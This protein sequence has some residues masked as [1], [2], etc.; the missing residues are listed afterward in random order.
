MRELIEFC[1]FTA[2]VFGLLTVLI[3]LANKP[4]KE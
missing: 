1:V 2:V 4:P 3:N